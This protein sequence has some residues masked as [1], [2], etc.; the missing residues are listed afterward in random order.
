MVAYTIDIQPLGRKGQCLRDESLLD[1]TQGIGTG[2]Y[3]ICGGLGSCKSCRIKVLSGDVSAPTTNETSFFSSQELRDGWRL[4]CQTYPYS[5]CKLNLPPESLTT[6]Q[7]MQVEG[8]DLFIQAGSPPIQSYRLH[9]NADELSLMNSNTGYLLEIINRQYQKQFQKIDNNVL[10]ALAGQARSLEWEYLAIARNDEIIALLHPGSLLLGLAID[11]GTT[12]IAGYLVNIEDGCTLAASGMMNPQ[13]SYGED[14]ISRI[15]NVTASA[16]KA[17]DMQ[18]LVVKAVGDL[19]MEL[20]N[21]IHTNTENIV[22]VVAVGNTAMHHLFLGLPIK[23]LAISPFTPAVKGPMNIKVKDLGLNFAPGAYVYLL[24][25]IAAFI[26]ADHVAMLLITELLKKDEPAIAIDI[27]T[28][29]E[30]SLIYK[31]KITSI[32]C[33]SGPA[34]EGG[35]IKDG[36]RAI[37][38]AI[39]RVIISENNIQYQTIDNMPP[40]GIC[41]SGILDAVAQMYLAGII[42]RKGRM[43]NNHPRIRI[44]RNQREFVLVSE[45]ETGGRQAITITQH[46]VREVQ[47]A[48]AAV[49]AGIQVLFDVNKLND[50][51]ISQIFIAGTFGNY[52]NIPSSLAIGMLPDLPLDRFYQIGN[53][54]GMGAKLALTS[55]DQRARA[56]QITSRI[57][58]IELAGVADFKEK[59]IRATYLGQYEGK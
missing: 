5:D 54:A 20:C 13:I 52:I 29:T 10:G 32:S 59:F 12:R 40:V 14:I 47:L 31:D 42:D 57:N 11:I 37:S 24:P 53:A 26:G 25:N 43:I 9:L 1:C 56:E 55:L 21:S 2:I 17:K 44:R 6:P 18:E 19:A 3:S 8:K 49:M 4:A 33:A 58:Y 46:D 23:Q 27:G 30:I 15:K 50:K 28:N 48:K 36:M 41:G 16:D 35:H 38:G 34:F 39:E 7:R 22:E 51:D 45:K